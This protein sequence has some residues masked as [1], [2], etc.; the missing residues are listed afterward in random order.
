MRRFGF[1]IPLVVAGF[2]WFLTER[3]PHLAFGDPLGP[4]VFPRL[5]AAGLVVSAG[6]WL[7][8]TR[9]AAGPEAGAA[10]TGGG[11]FAA[12]AAVAGLL[13]V[14]A[15]LLVPVGYVLSTIVFLLVL[16]FYFHRAAPVTNVAV[17]VLFPILTYLAFTRLLGVSLPAGHLT[18]F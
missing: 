8:E 16:T 1:A 5:L 6:L 3:I 14:Y 10:D 2:Y 18:A 7:L 15:V 11:H 17:S 13:L 9:S 4:R 12:A